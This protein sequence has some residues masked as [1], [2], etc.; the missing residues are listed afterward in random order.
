[1]LL[2]TQSP[3]LIPIR[4]SQVGRSIKWSNNH[5][6]SYNNNSLK[7]SLTFDQ[8]KVGLAW[9]AKGNSCSEVMTT[10]VSCSFS[11]IFTGPQDQHLVDEDTLEEDGSQD[12]ELQGLTED[13]VYT[14]MRFSRPFRSCDPH[15]QDITVKQ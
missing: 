7:L 14:T 2:V 10:G 3:A 15:D 6:S 8:P 9:V 5:S 1:M 12:A 13:A 4:L 11:L